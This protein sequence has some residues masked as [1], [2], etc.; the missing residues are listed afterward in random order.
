MIKI[1]VSF[2]AV[3]I[4]C[5]SAYAD[6]ETAT[7]GYFSAKAGQYLNNS[8]NEKSSQ[9]HR[10]Q[11]EQETHVNADLTLINQ[12]RW[13]YSSVYTDLSS[14]P[15]PDSKETHKI[16]MGDNYIKYKSSSWVIQTGYQEVAWGEAFGFNYADIINPKDLKETFYSDYSE[17]R[18]PLFLTNFKYFFSDGSIQLLYS[19][20]PRFSENLPTDLFT[21]SILPQMSVESR[22]QETPDFFKVHEY[23]GKIS[24]SFWGIDTSVFYFSYLDRDARYSLKSANLTNVVLQEEHSRI[25]TTAF[26]LAKTLFNDYVIRTDVV[27]TKNKKIN[28][29]SGTKLISSPVNMTNALVSLDTP[30]YHNFSAVLIFAV[31]QLSRDIPMALREKEQKYS[32]AKVSYDFGEDKIAD[33]SYTHEFSQT[34]HG[35]QG[36]FTWPVNSTFDLRMGAETYW[37]DKASEL[38]KIKNVSNVFFGIKNYFQL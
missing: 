7:R 17:S 22:K 1:A 16:F 20:E 8:T 34:G 6:V 35:I 25:N 18:I 15:S 33:L 37:G 36:L 26:S 23:G 14:H 27:Y 2:L 10:A 24:T 28:A 13:S 32:I 4:P 38:Y 30:T 3:I 12:L 5:F 29:L 21:K 9:R 19:P 31:S 11:I